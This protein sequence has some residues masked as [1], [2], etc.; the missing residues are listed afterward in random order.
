M[1]KTARASI[2][3]DPEIEEHVRS[4]LEDREDV[5][6]RACF[7]TDTL[8]WTVVRDAR[9]RP[10]Y[11]LR[12]KS[13]PTKCYIQ[14][15]KWEI[16][17]YSDEDI[18]ARIITGN[19]ES[20]CD[21][22]ATLAARVA[23]WVERLDELF[24]W[25]VCWLEERPEWSPEIAPTRQREEEWL[26]VWGVEPRDVPV[27]TVRSGDRHVRFVP[28]ALLIIGAN[29][30]VDVFDSASHHYSLVDRAPD[31]ASCRD[32]QIAIP[33]ARQILQTFTPAVFHDLL[34]CA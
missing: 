7:T 3:Y 4:T 8:Q 24:E 5:F 1:P 25:V 23:R 9:N 12:K 34:D 32:W 17:Q 2:E 20:R 19:G 18:T 30:R 21:D 29:G 14:L 33:G 11:R 13:Q 6:V 31:D 28:D 26:E 16:E 27:L 15:V 10:Y 22:K